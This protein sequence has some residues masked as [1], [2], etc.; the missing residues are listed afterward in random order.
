LFYIASFQVKDSEVIYKNT[1]WYKI[2]GISF[3]N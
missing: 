3:E 2:K 1:I